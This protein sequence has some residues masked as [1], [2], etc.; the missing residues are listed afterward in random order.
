MIEAP[1]YAGLV[2]LSHA[3][4]DGLSVTD[5][6]TILHRLAYTKQRLAM[7]AAA[8]LPSTPEWEVK[9][10]LALHAWMDAEHAA[11]LYARIAEMR[12]P[13]PSAADVP[14]A[15][16][17]GSRTSTRSDRRAASRASH[18]HGRRRIGP[19]PVPIHATRTPMTRAATT[20]AR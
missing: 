5:A 15:A 1:P 18:R 7:T 12:E 8:Y 19:T 11:A 9:C 14:D 10:A 4:Q 6:T 13:P 17:D 2:D 3:V 20:Q 16:L